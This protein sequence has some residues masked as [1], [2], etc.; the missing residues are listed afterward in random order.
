MLIRAAR[1]VLACQT[2]RPRR[3][4]HQSGLNDV[5]RL[6]FE[7]LEERRLLAADFDFGDAPDS[8]QILDASGGAKHEIG[9]LFLGTYVDGEPDGN[10]SLFAEDDD[11]DQLPNDEDGLVRTSQ[12]I[13]GQ[14][15]SIDVLVSSAGK[16]DAWMDLNGNGQFDHPDEH[17]N[18]GTSVPVDEVRWG[19]T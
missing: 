10:P 3:H 9:S 1:P 15:P 16:L 17:I 6:L 13:I 5:R 19:R 8:Y 11:D 18:E 14:Q 7:G 4:R 2:R 12:F